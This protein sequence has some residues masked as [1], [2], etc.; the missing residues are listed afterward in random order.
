VSWFT[1][2]GIELARVASHPSPPTGERRDIG[3]Q[4]EAADGSAI[5]T[6]QTT[7]RDRKFSLKPLS[8]DDAFAWEGL[9]CGDAHVWSFDSSLYSSKGL[10]GVAT[11]PTVIVQAV[12]KKY[13]ANALIVPSGQQFAATLPWDVEAGTV[14][15]WVRAEAD[16]A[17][18]YW[19][20]QRSAGKFWLDGVLTG[21][22]PTSGDMLDVTGAVVTL[23]T[24]D[25][26]T[27]FDDLVVCPYVWPDDW[28]LQV[29]NAGQPF[30]L[31]PY[32]TCAGDLVP[33][34]ATRRMICAGVSDRVTIANLGA[35]D[36]LERDVRQL[37]VQLKGA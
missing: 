4:R 27:Y 10:A 14:A 17:F 15:L 8:G 36:G 5:L 34:A 7:K 11:D 12:E 18:H 22:L 29:C 6:R 33:E 28:P 26:W 23:G 16:A 19:V 30:G 2:N 9:L 13:G 24:P 35:G 3:A 37:E 1:V 21:S 25:D 20:F 32:L 31:A